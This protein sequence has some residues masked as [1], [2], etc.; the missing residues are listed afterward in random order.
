MAEWFGISRE[1]VRLWLKDGIPT[2]RA[3]EVEEATVRCKPPVT[4]A[5]VLEHARQRK[6]E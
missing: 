2:D 1:A 3:L 4:A 5:E 6:T